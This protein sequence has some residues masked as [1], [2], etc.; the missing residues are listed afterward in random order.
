MFFCFNDQYFC[1]KIYYRNLEF[2]FYNLRLYVLYIKF[3][4]LIFLVIDL[5]WVGL[6]FCLQERC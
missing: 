5:Y 1:V 6:I 3:E 2:F 4:F